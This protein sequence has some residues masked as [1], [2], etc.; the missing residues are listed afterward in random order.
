M[1][2]LFPAACAACDA[3][4]WGAPNPWF[5]HPCWDEIGVN[6]G[7]A[8]V[9]DALCACCGI[10]IRSSVVDRVAG[11]RCGHCIKTPPA[12]HMARVLGPYDGPLGAALRLLKYHGYTGMAPAL[13]ER[14][15]LADLPQELLD[16]DLV[17]P[18]P[19]HP[20]RLRSR[21]FNQAGRLARAVGRRLAKPVLEDV[22]ERSGDGTSQ[23][24]LSRAQRLANIRGVFRVVGQPQLEGK[25][26]LLV[27]DVMTTGATADACAKALMRAGADRVCVWAM[28]RQGLM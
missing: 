20:K 17:L 9:G 19:L 21:G 12:Y 8:K 4:L 27:D 2:L 1:E 15:P 5:C 16:S 23:V 14:L 3:R 22:L 11:W 10:T 18:V 28:A 26:L 6:A 24:G 13:A 25:R 7:Q